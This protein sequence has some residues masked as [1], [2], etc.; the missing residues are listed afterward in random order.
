MRATL[1]YVTA[2]T[3]SYDSLWCA[4]GAGPSSSPPRTRLTPTAP[5]YSTSTCRPSTQTSRPRYDTPPFPALTRHVGRE[6]IVIVTHT[7][8]SISGSRLNLPWSARGRLFQWPV[9]F[10]LPGL[11]ERGPPGPSPVAATESSS[12]NRSPVLLLRPRRSQ[13]GTARDIYCGR[14]CAL[15][16]RS[17]FGF[18]GGAAAQG[19]SSVSVIIW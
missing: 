10:S 4:Y 2:R 18:G 13:Y 17:G 15:N 19:N 14:S 1:P 11:D 9:T 16:V 8:D 3:S 12:N 7:T 6:R 5:S